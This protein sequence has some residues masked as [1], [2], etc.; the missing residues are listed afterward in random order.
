MN[1]RFDIEKNLE[2]LFREEEK[3]FSL[4]NTSEIMKST[5]KYVEYSKIEYKKRKKQFCFLAVSS[6]CFVLIFSFLTHN[7]YLPNTSQPST[8]THPPAFVVH[9]AWTNS[10]SHYVIISPIA[11]TEEKIQ[12]G[13]DKHTTIEYTA[14]EC[15]ITFQWYQTI[16]GINVSGNIEL[17]TPK[18]K[19]YIPSES[20]EDVM[21]YDNLLIA[22][23]RDYHNEFPLCQIDSNGFAEYIP[24]VNGKAQIDFDLSET[25][26]FKDI[27][28][29]NFA[30]QEMKNIINSSNNDFSVSYANAYPQSPISNGTSIPD[31]ISFFSDITVAQNLYHA[32]WEQIYMY[33]E[34]HGIIV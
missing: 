29:F 33:N 13:H 15:E 4:P 19:I 1:N 24:Y 11:V 27:S 7:Y 21:K 10:Y 14:L 17:S 20:V 31:T 8:P 22:K 2:H 34:K 3:Q 6:I 32:Y 23:Q 5:S 12:L 28:V 9:P 18:D 16:K 26:S 25:N 30:I